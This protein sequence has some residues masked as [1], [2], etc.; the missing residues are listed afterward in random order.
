MGSELNQ[1]NIKTQDMYKTWWFILTAS[2]LIHCQCYSPIAYLA[3]V[4]VFGVR[5]GFF[6]LSFRTND[7][8]SNICDSKDA[9][10]QICGFFLFLSSIQLSLTVIPADRRRENADMLKGKL[11]QMK[12]R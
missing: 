8:H 7:H 1:V 4:E 6:I 5:R 2:H 12:T 11:W 3:P 9:R 10:Q